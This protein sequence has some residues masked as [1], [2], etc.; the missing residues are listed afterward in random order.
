MTEGISL[1]RMR[2]PLLKPFR[3][4]RSRPRLVVCVAIG[5]VLGLALPH[6]LRPATRALIAW[7]AAVLGYLASAFVMIARA[8][9]ET[10][11]RRARFQDEGRLL[12]LML[13]IGAA[14]ASMGAIV[15]ELGPVKNMQGWPKAL[16]LGL[17]VLTVIDSWMFMHLTFAIHYAHEYYDELRANPAK[18]LEE[19]GGLVFP[20]GEPP[21]YVDFLYYA[22]VIGLA[23]QTADVAT[24]SRSMRM[25]TAVHGGLAFFYNLAIIGLTVNIASGIV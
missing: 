16:H 14:C 4:L 21:N 18:K 23:S 5:V 8:D 3:V 20:G 2:S 1:R 22:Y 25:L 11:R 12:I 17:T 10:V 6:Y 7:N 15:L 19:R 13:A 9:Q 24:T